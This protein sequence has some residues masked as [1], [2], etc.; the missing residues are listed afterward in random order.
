MAMRKDLIEELVQESASEHSDE[1]LGADDSPNDENY[2][3]TSDEE[4]APEIQ[5][6]DEQITIETPD[7]IQD[8]NGQRWSTKAQMVAVPQIDVM[9]PEISETAA[10]AE[11]P[12]VAFKLLFMPELG[13]IIK[14]F[15][16]LEIR[17]KKKERKRNI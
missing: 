11:S 16:N 5:E 6:A 1:N 12:A 14:H 3:V 2:V 8:Q 17:K 10:N 7:T 15:T 9:L 13:E 4:A